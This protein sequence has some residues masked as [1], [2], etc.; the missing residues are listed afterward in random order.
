MVFA[1]AAFI[2]PLLLITAILSVINSFG[3][4]SWSGEIIILT[5]IY[6]IGLSVIATKAIHKFGL[7]RAIDVYIIS[8]I[9]IPLLVYIIYIT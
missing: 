3:W 6:A 1:N 5:W 7:G 8:L 9:G 2:M 4:I